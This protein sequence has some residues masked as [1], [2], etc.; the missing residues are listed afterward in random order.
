MAVSCGRLQKACPKKWC[1]FELTIYLTSYDPLDWP[2]VQSRN[3]A[4]FLIIFLQLLLTWYWHRYSFEVFGY[5]NNQLAKLLFDHYIEVCLK[6]L[7]LDYA[8]KMKKV[9]RS[10][11]KNKK[12]CNSRGYVLWKAPTGLT[13]E[14]VCFRIKHILN[15]IWPPRLAHSAVTKPSY[16]FNNFLQ[17]LLTWYWHRYSFEVFGYSYNQLAKLLFVHYI[18]V[19]LKIRCLA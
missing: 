9:P 18:A 8:L 10:V 1:V 17:L 15:I 7:C 5:S 19:C 12:L 13:K 16:F 3:P 2:I 14:M 6:T 4:I 11:I